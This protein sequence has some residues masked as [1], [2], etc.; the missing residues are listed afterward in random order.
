MGL[1]WALAL[2]WTIAALDWRR[3][4]LPDAVRFAAPWLLSGAAVIAWIWPHRALAALQ[5]ST[6]TQ[7]RW[8]AL[9]HPVGT[10]LRD[11]IDRYVFF[12]MPSGGLL[13]RSKILIVA[14]YAVFIAVFFASALR[15]RRIRQSDAFRVLG[16]ALLIVYC[17]VALLDGVMYPYY[18]IHTFLFASAIVAIAA[19]ELRTTR[20]RYAAAVGIAM[21]LLLQIGGIGLKVRENSYARQ[22]LP[23]VRYIRAHTA[24]GQYVEGDMALNFGLGVSNPDF[25]MDNRMGFLTGIRPAMIVTDEFSDISYFRGHEPDVY[26]FIRRR[27]DV[28]YREVANFGEY[29]IYQP[30]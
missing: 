26:R 25:H 30:R 18:M 10:I 24:P 16:P 2:V 29:H 12:Y 19:A 28:E 3:I 1:T 5:F 20:F 15:T 27:L 13:A 6:N 21:L 9:A 17:A 11:A 23:A 14:L 4:R 8:N 22:F 7:A